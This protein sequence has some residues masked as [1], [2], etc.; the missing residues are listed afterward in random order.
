MMHGS[1]DME[2]NR[3]NF[4][5]EPFFCPF[6]TIATQKIKIFKNEKTHRNII[7]HKCTIN[8]NHMMYGS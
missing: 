6:T 7:L 8:N 2:R 5:F 3:H 1:W 4:H